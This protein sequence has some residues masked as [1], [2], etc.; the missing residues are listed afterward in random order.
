M[1]NKNHYIQN[2]L[3]KNFAIKAEN[4]K[5]KICVLDLIK[6]DAN[7]RNT[8]NCF[9]QKNLYDIASGDDVKELEKKF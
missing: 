3:L 1:L 5:Y 4:G 7:Y 2:R 8:D 6:F 9:C